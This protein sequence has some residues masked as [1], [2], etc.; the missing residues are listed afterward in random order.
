MLNTLSDA[1][2]RTCQLAEPKE[3]E[4]S[5][6]GRRS[7]LKCLTYRP[8]ITQQRLVHVSLVEDRQQGIYE[9]VLKSLSTANGWEHLLNAGRDHLRKTYLRC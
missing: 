6:Y 2:A 7:W 9:D 1:C 8:L 4:R 5:C 3:G